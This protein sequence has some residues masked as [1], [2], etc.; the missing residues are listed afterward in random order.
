M[1]KLIRSVFKNKKAA[2]S[3]ETIWIF[4]GDQIG[5]P[6]LTELL[7]R[8]GI[9]KS[10]YV[11]CSYNNF[12]GIGREKRVRPINVYKAINGDDK[13]G[14]LRAKEATDKYI[15][16]LIQRYV[17]AGFSEFSVVSSDSDFLDIAN[18]VIAANK[19]KG[20]YFK[21]VVH[22][23]TNGKLKEFVDTDN[24]K[25]IHDLSIKMPPT[26]R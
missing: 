16:I 15:A 24:I 26:Q 25:V 10:H 23:K 17:S 8:Y 4:D 7:N 9:K 18:M 13:V 5:L 20:L 22:S 3:R 12:A 1:F 6:K 21:I 14:N 11:Y 2:A 19:D